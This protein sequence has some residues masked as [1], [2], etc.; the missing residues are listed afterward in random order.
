MTDA[1]G[2][3]VMVGAGPAGSAPVGNPVLI[4]GTDGS[5]VR[6]LLTDASGNIQVGGSVN[7]SGGVPDVTASGTISGSGQTV[8]LAVTGSASVSVLIN[9]GTLS[10]TLIPQVSF[11]GGTTW[12]NSLWYQTSTRKMVSSLALAGGGGAFGYTF[13]PRGGASNYRVRCTAF[14]S[15]ASGTISLRGSQIVDITPE[16]EAQVGSTPP[17]AAAYIAALQTNTDGSSSNT[18]RPLAVDAVGHLLMVPDPNLTTVL[19]NATITASG[20]SGV[21]NVGYGAKEVSLYIDIPVAPTGTN[22]T[23][24]FDIVEM[25]PNQLAFQISQHRYGA[26]FTT[27]GQQV[28]TIPSTRSP[29]IQINWTVGGSTPSWGVYL[30]VGCK[31]YGAA[32]TPDPGVD[33]I[34][35]Q[36]AVTG[37]TTLYTRPIGAREADFVIRAVNTGSADATLQF[38]AF[39]FDPN[40]TTTFGQAIAQSGLIQ[41]GTGTTE[42]ILH[43][44]NVF[45]SAIALQLE[46]G[47]TTPS[48]TMTVALLQKV[49]GGPYLS[50]QLAK[51]NFGHIQT[52]GRQEVFIGSTPYVEQATNAIRSVSSTSP[53]DASGGTGAR[54]VQVTYYTAPNGLPGP[55]DGPFTE[56]ISLNGTTPVDSAGTWAL[57]ESAVIT[58]FG[59][60]GQNDGTIQFW[61]GANGT[62]SIFASIA[63][64][65]NETRYAHHYVPTG[66]CCHVV[67]ITP[68]SSSPTGNSS[69][70]ALKSLRYDQGNQSDQ[71]V[72]GDVLAGGSA[73]GTFIPFPVVKRITGPARIRIYATPSGIV[74]QT[75]SADFQY[76]EL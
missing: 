20:N 66:R 28:I 19:N 4:A 74:G 29:Y 32:S 46:I 50:A 24:Y 2:R 53:N 76:Y 18:A 40:S 23:I 45:S 36:I 10:G 55:I 72:V 44:P 12:E 67:G 60:D 71:I 1:S 6:T 15:G 14:T 41:A 35:N 34:M 75:T 31:H 5:N 37:T 13:Q 21:L 56:A 33:L 11:D 62:G 22:P 42:F 47:G 26:Q 52:A 49:A 30:K 57:L 51:S 59:T 25:D 48:W 27:S 39:E 63:P 17:T 16:Y 61:T 7:L 54:F 43:I 8:S 69:R 9:G 70:F 68:S 65:D 3:P 38:F 64:G 58:F 73:S